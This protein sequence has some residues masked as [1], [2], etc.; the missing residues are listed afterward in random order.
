MKKV[1]PRFDYDVDVGFL[2]TKKMKYSKARSL[3]KK[4]FVFSLV[5]SILGCIFVGLGSGYNI[6][7]YR[8]GMLLILSG[9]VSLSY[10]IIIHAAISWEPSPEEVEKILREKSKKRS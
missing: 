10:S 8:I 7:I 1:N 6:A 2:F 3:R 9:F 4:H 5:L